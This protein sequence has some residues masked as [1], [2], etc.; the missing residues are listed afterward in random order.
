MTA[1]TLDIILA[2]GVLLFVANGF[3]QGIIHML[4]SLLGLIVG[5]G[6][7]S[8][9]DEA[10]GVWLSGAVGIPKS[11]AT[12]VG[13]VVVLLIFTRVFGFSLHLLEK[14][15]K[16][17]KLPFVGLANRLLGGLLGFFEGVLIIGS[18]LL[19]SGVLPFPDL[20]KAIAGSG[21]AASLASSAKLLLPLLPKQIRELYY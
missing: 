5:I 17:M 9:A 12:L 1:A 4:G 19:I 15:F 16:F 3:Y 10:V 6:V 2:V 11:V 8:R 7:A 20:A 14:T 18:T 21:L 13:F